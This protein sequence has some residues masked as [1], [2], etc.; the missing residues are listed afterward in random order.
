MISSALPAIFIG[1]GSPMNILADNLFTHDLI[2]LRDQLLEPE[3]ILVIS[4]H[5]LTR[6][7]H[8]TTSQHPEQMYDFHGFPG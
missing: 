1:H 8:I 2:R 3:A 5:W 7:T 6:G 4:A